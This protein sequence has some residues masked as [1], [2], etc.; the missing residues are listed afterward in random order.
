MTRASLSSHLAKVG[1]SYYVDTSALFALAL[2]NSTA[3]QNQSALPQLET[4]RA[5]SFEQFA[6]RTRTAGGLL[7]ASSIVI[8]EVVATFL[9]RERNKIAS[10]AGHGNWREFKK[11]DRAKAEA[12]ERTLWPHAAKFYTTAQRTIMLVGILVQDPVVAPSATCSL[13]TQGGCMKKALTSRG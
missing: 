10:R 2:R 11:A 6:K 13:V 7:I 4:K 8:E 1:E 9:N 3:P 5:N 12:E